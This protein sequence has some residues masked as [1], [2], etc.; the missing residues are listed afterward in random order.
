MSNFKICVDI[1]LNLKLLTAHICLHPQNLSHCVKH[2]TVNLAALVFQKISN[3]KPIVTPTAWKISASYKIPKFISQAQGSGRRFCILD[4]R[5]PPPTDEKH[6]SKI[7]SCRVGQFTKTSKKEEN[8][9]VGFWPA[10]LKMELQTWP[11]L[12]S[13]FLSLSI[14]FY[15]LK[16]P[17][18]FQTE[19]APDSYVVT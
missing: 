17:I 15:P 1:V 11:F 16:Y 9:K 8:P 13:I 18:N 3:F 5:T 4:R 6:F 12:C 7:S 10:V 2:G 14:F 19:K